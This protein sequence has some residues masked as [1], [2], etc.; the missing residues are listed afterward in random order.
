MSGEAH[1]LHK[2]PKHPPHEKSHPVATLMFFTFP[3]RQTGPARH[4]PC[5]QPVH[6]VWQAGLRAGLDGS[7]ASLEA[8]ENKSLSSVFKIWASKRYQEPAV[9]PAG[10]DGAVRTPKNTYF[11][12]PL[13]LYVS[14]EAVFTMIS[15]FAIWNKST[16]NPYDVSTFIPIKYQLGPLIASLRLTVG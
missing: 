5:V 12:L 13:Q 14:F 3:N 2:S 9:P 16:F 10:E 8:L 1:P 4:A 11:L 7:V 6:G 15:P